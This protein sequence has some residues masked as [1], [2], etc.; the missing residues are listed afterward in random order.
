VMEAWDN[1]ET[2]ILVKISGKSGVNPMTAKAMTYSPG[3][4]RMSPV[5]P[6]VAKNLSHMERAFTENRIRW[7]VS[8][9]LDVRGTLSEVMWVPVS[10][11]RQAQR[12][13]LL[14]TDFTLLGAVDREITD[15]EILG[16]VPNFDEVRF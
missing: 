13:L 12:E 11:S 16:F 15:E 3:I 8:E 6:D 10:E 5:T 7:M 14:D 2:G 9:D 1:P 4:V